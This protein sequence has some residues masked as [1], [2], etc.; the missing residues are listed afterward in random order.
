MLDLLSPFAR[1]GALIALLLAGAVIT[2]PGFGE[3]FGHAAGSHMFL[4][5]GL[6]LVWFAWPLIRFALREFFTGLFLGWGI[7]ESGALRDIFPRPP[8]RS[9]RRSW[10][11]IWRMS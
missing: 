6:I 8:R 2:Q 7:R 3:N 1:A 5:G 4:I 11:R 10:W 9:I